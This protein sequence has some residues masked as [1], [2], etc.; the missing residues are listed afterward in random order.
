MTSQPPRHTERRPMGLFARFALILFGVLAVGAVCTVSAVAWATHAV[1]TSPMV[2]VRVQEHV[3]ERMSF[4][5]S[6]PAAAISAGLVVAPHLVPDATWDQVRAEMEAE[7]DGVSPDLRPAAARLVRDLGTL[8]DATLVEVEDGGDHVLV[9]K[10]GREIQ[11]TVR[12]PD[13]DVDVSVPVEL[14]ERVAAF[15]EG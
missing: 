3:G 4:E 13:A 7:M 2:H 11:V 8:P 15:V 5:L 9:V 10:R 6:V 14:L 12:S 1:V